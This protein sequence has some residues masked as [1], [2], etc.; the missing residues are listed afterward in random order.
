MMLRFLGCFS[1]LINNQVPIIQSLTVLENATYNACLKKTISETKKNVT[2]GHPI[3]KA[4]LKNKSLI[5]PMV[6]YSISTGEKSGNLGPSLY[7]V[8]EFINEE[9]SL[10]MKKLSSQLEPLLTLILG[11]MVLFIALAIYLPIFD[12]MLP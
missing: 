9:L 1:I 3:S 5:S 4:L 6:A 2:R 12:I 7:R 11:A 8:S 10:N